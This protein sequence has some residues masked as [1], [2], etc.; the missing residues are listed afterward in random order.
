VPESTV[1]QEV[2]KQTLVQLDL[3]G[4]DF[5]RSLAAIYKKSKVLSPAMK[6]FIN[7]L[8]GE[9]GEEKPV[10]EKPARS[11]RELVAA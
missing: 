11:R 5:Y 6:Q 8:K 1:T 10:H 7:I 3:E 9:N 4:A 2:N